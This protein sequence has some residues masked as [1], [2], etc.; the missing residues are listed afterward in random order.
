[1]NLEYLVHGDEGAKNQAWETFYYD[2][3]NVKQAL[4]KLS[5]ENWN[6]VVA[7][8]LQWAGSPAWPATRVAR[9]VYQLTGHTT[10]G[11]EHKEYLNSFLWSLALAAGLD[12]A[13]PTMTQDM[14]EVSFQQADRWA[15]PQD[16][17]DT[18]MAE[19]EEQS[20]KDTEEDEHLPWMPKPDRLPEDLRLIL[21]KVKNNER[22][23]CKKFFEGIPT[24]RELRTTP[25]QN[26]HRGDAQNQ[27]DKMLRNF[28]SKGGIF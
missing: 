9:V 26:N 24:Y 3:T 2:E 25:F 8:G 21:K 27:I 10:M 28:E 12:M 22:M 1:M 19:E 11:V 5:K 18:E 17:K 15:A 13:M 14:A 4:G 6:E 16:I 23:D 7:A 20:D